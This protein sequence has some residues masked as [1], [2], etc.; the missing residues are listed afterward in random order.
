[1][2]SSASVF[3]DAC[4]A[5]N[6]PQSDHCAVCGNSLQN[7]L[8]SSH[9]QPALSPANKSITARPLLKGRYKMVHEIGKGG[10]GA[11]YKAVD[12]QLAERVVAIKEMSHDHLSPQESAE[13]T[14]HFKQEVF[15][16][17][18]LKH[19]NLPGIYDYFLEAGRWYV[20]MDFIE[21]ETL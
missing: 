5:A 13:A 2:T 7:R 19:P 10:F 18:R 8:T 12:T 6:V 15:L 3:C 20:V 4:G 16:L 17:A 14:E 21:G 1:M 11:V 9:K